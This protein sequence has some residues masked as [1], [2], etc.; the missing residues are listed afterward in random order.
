MTTSANLI[1]ITGGLNLNQADFNNDGFLDVFVMRGGW[2]GA[3]GLHPNSLLNNNGDRTFKDIAFDAGLADKNR[4]TQ[5]SSWADFDLDGDLDLLIGNEPCG[6]PSACQLFRNNGNETFTDVAAEAGVAMEAFTKAVI[7]GDFNNDRWPDFYMSNFNGANYLFQNNGDGKKFKNVTKDMGVEMP[8]ASFPTWFWDYDNDG[9]LDLFVGSYSGTVVDYAQFAINGEFKSEP[10]RL[11][12]NLGDRF[13]NR[14]IEAGVSMPNSP[15][16]SNF[17]D[18]N[19][20]GYL[21]FY[22]GTGWP[23]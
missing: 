22:L 4:P 3:A 13:E 6:K 17:G 5:T 18:V 23:E 20:D 15:M 11:Y 10:P 8:K 7:W 19:N 9:K 1:G 16:G 14:A 2:F 21:D 12:K